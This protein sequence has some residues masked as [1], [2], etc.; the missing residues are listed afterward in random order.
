MLYVVQLV[1][2]EDPDD[3]KCFESHDKA[4][5]HARRERDAGNADLINIYCVSGATNPYEAAAC[6]DRGDAKLVESY[7]MPY[8]GPGG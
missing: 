8:P 5:V 2:S 3:L 7:T 1:G 6:V 4:R